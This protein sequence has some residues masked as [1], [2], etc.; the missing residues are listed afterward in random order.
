MELLDHVYKVLP[1]LPLSERNNLYD[2]L[3]RAATSVVGNLSEGLSRM[4]PADKIHR[5]C[6][7]RSECAEVHSYFLFMIKIG[8]MDRALLEQGVQL[9]IRTG[10]LI[11]GLIKAQRRR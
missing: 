7:A 3:Q 11:T 6:I 1:L 4:T 8:Y 2:Q 9:A 5:F 10:K